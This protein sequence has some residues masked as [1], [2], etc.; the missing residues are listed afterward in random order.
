MKGWNR[1]LRKQRLVSYHNFVGC[2]VGMF[3][4]LSIL[5]PLIGCTPWTISKKVSERYLRTSK[6]IRHY[7]LV[8]H[9][10][11][12]TNQTQVSFFFEQDYTRT[13][14]NFWHTPCTP[15]ND[16]KRERLNFCI[17]VYTIM[18][19]FPF[20]RFII[21]YIINP[22]VVSINKWLINGVFHLG[23]RVWFMRWSSNW[24]FLWSEN[25]VMTSYHALY[26]NNETNNV[27]AVNIS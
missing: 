13:F 25:I 9:F 1:S 7:R 18:N 23:H 27:C 20:V 5:I 16:I 10:I 26:Y 22:V 11:V 4:N 17:R 15:P 21:V 24:L 14:T 19:I 8:Q 6:I 12:E 2:F 3:F